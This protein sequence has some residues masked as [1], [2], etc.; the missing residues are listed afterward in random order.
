MSDV[1]NVIRFATSLPEASASYEGQVMQYIGTTTDTYK[2]N[3]MYQCVN[4]SGIYTWEIIDYILRDEMY[5]IMNNAINSAITSVLEG[6][7]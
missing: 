6:S 2:N 1:S 5:V 3:Y 7:Y 4:N